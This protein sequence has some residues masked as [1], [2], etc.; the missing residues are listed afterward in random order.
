M[1]VWVCVF[2]VNIWFGMRNPTRV[3]MF[4]VYEFIFVVVVAVASE[5][6]KKPTI[7]NGPWILWNCLA[8]FDF[9][10][11]LNGHISTLI[12]RRQKNFCR[13]QEKKMV[14]R[15]LIYSM[16]IVAVSLILHTHNSNLYKHNQFSITLNLP[17]HITI[18]IFARYRTDSKTASKT[19]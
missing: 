10:P 4:F 13:L 1:W 3:W 6:K 8:Q 9:H 19:K 15:I 16:H 14:L 2:A 18:S 11:Q 12:F 17:T 5:H 7:K